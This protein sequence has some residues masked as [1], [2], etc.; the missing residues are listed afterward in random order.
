[1]T[2][3]RLRRAMTAL[4][5]CLFAVFGLFC[6]GTAQGQIMV[7]EIIIV[8]NSHTSDAAIRRQIPFFTGQTITGEHLRR[9][10]QNLIRLDRFE[11]DEAKGIR[12]TVQVLD[13]PGAF[14]NILVK[15]Q[16][17]PVDENAWIFWAAAIVGLLIVVIA[18]V[19]A[20]VWWGLR[21]KPA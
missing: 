19:L 4:R 2:L 8:G 12:P 9:A 14:K 7:G 20:V 17:K 10:E 21:M 18:V 6:A 11:V 1:M 15:V 13:G 5:N 3:A 16:E